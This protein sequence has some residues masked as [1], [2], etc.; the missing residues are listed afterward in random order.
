MK[1]DADSLYSYKDVKVLAVLKPPYSKKYSWSPFKKLIHNYNS[2][3]EF[4]QLAKELLEC[5]ITEPHPLNSKDNSDTALFLTDKGLFQVGRVLYYDSYLHKIYVYNGIMKQ[6]FSSLGRDGRSTDLVTPKNSGSIYAACVGFLPFILLYFHLEKPLFYI[7][8]TYFSMLMVAVYCILA[9]ILWN[10]ISKIIGDRVITFRDG[11]TSKHFA[12]NVKHFD[13][14][15]LSEFIKQL[16]K[17][18]GELSKDWKN[19]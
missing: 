5:A 15:Q 6:A 10:L 8:S 19:K 16:D 3:M 7:S 1:I 14:E 4:S 2:T 9:F 13:K 12:L 11:L 18:S 17:L